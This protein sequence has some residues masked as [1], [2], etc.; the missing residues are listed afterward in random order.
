VVGNSDA[1][2]DIWNSPDGITW[3]QV[4]A[5]AP[6]KTRLGAGIAAFHENLWVLG[7][8]VTTSGADPKDVWNS[9]DGTQ[10][11]QIGEHGAWTPLRLNTVVF[12]DRLWLIG[13]YTP[14]IMGGYEVYDWAHDAANSSTGESWTS[15]PS[16]SV[17][18]FGSLA[19]FDNQLWDTD[20][21]YFYEVLQ[22]GIEIEGSNEV[23]R[24]QDAA[25]WQQMPDAP[26]TS[27]SS[28]AIV[29]F[30]GKLWVL[31][32]MR[33]GLLP[34]FTNNDVWNLTPVSLSIDTGQHYLYNA[35]DPMTLK[36][37]ASEL[38]GTVHYQWSK[39]GN[40]ISDAT[41]DTYHV[42]AFSADDAGTYTCELTGD[43]FGTAGPVQIGVAPPRVP[44]ARPVG[45]ILGIAVAASIL[46]LRR[47]PSRSRAR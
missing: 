44:A 29:V 15:V 45:L 42:D 24:S 37:K 16:T 18:Y 5:D 8:E 43:T 25:H 14:I 13:G 28:Q 33:W 46:V 34:C 32:G 12:Q 41:S 10:W 4:T 26:W 1:P 31:G 36:V 17:G 21:S 7:G 22:T 47:L 38:S 23:W 2:N 6:W 27:R 30:G 40:A 35:G 9:S 39:N 3:T 19:V 20:R 11:T